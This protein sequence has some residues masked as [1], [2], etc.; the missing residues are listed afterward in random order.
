MGISISLALQK[1]S[2]RAI[3]MLQVISDATFLF[4]CVCQLTVQLCASRG[5]EGASSFQ[6][7]MEK[8]ARKQRK[9]R[10]CF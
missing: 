4:V 5:G 8:D 3:K 6:S 10:A 9:K 2:I 1:R 7:E